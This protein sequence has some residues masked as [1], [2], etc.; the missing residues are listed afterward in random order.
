[1]PPAAGQC[2]SCNM[3]INAVEN[4]ESSGTIEVVNPF[5]VVNVV[6]FLRRFAVN[7]VWHIC[8]VKIDRY[9]A[10]VGSD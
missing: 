7:K 5:I 2:P 4:I 3:S 9:F 10:A 1:M 6:L 8:N